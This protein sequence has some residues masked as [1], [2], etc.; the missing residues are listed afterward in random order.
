[1]PSARPASAQLPPR[2]SELVNVAGA[3]KHAHGAFS[4]PLDIGGG[5]IA[6]LV[7]SEPACAS[8]QQMNR[9]LHPVNADVCLMK[10]VAL[11]VGRSVARL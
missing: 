11:E 1:M 5:G 3:V 10:R 7:A 6:P 2:A 8:S 4:H 9:E